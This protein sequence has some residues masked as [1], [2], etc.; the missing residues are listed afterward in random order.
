MAAVLIFAPGVLGIGPA[1]AEPA[2]APAAASDFY[3]IPSAMPGIDG[4][5]IKTEPVALLAGSPLAALA[6]PAS[7]TRIMYQSADTYGAPVAT[8]GIVLNPAAPWGGSGPR[9][10][11][12]VAVGTH[13]EGDACAPSRLLADGVTVDESGAPAFEMEMADIAALLSRGIAVVVSDYQ[14]LGTGLV[15]TYLQ[16]VPEA[17]AVLD[18]ARAAIRTGVVKPN[19][20]VGVWG[21]S[22]GGQA[23][24]ATAERAAGYAPDVDLVGTV[25]AAPPV[26]VT[27]T[28]R[29]VDGKFLSGAI[30]FFVNGLLASH[31]EL[32]E[33]IISKLNPAGMDFLRETAQQCAVGI[34]L[35]RSFGPTSKFTVSGQPLTDV[36]ESDPAI[37]RVLG[38]LDLRN[39]AVP[40]KPVLLM[41]NVHDDV[42]IP[43]LTRQLADHWCS[44][45]ATVEY[46]DKVDTPPLLPQIG[47]LGHAAITAG[48]DETVQWLVDRFTGHSVP[49]GC[50]A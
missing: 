11:V 18:A 32:T 49:R 9:P 17:H 25:V 21:I 7:A 43:A 34:M 20:P 6:F 44:N 5:V 33:S 8:T 14:G 41:Q 39:G 29:N 2:A 26:S 40:D 12:S 45:G 15:H 3:Q 24:G 28:M 37:R 4:A 23:A 13:G 47:I 22:Q 19:A 1:T 46:P 16:P 50:T 35:T 42:V 36:L 31:P 27:A 30:G 10:L 48:F 38:S